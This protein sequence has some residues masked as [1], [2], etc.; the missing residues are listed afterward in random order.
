[1]R[2]A[3]TE[4]EIDQFLDSSVCTIM[5]QKQ[6]RFLHLCEIEMSATY[7]TASLRVIL[8]QSDTCL[9][10]A[11]CHDVTFVLGDKRQ[12][13][14]VILHCRRHKSGPRIRCSR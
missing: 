12:K 6:Q 3:L 5:I 2:L 11:I 10:H 4:L 8:Q 13:V 9:D 1:M 14:E 7:L